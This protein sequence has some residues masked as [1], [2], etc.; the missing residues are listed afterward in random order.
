MNAQLVSG[1]WQVLVRVG[2]GR[3]RR[4][5]VWPADWRLQSRRVVAHGVAQRVLPQR[6]L[7]APRRD[8]LLVGGFTAPA[9]S[10]GGQID[11]LAERDQRITTHRVRLAALS[12][13]RPHWLDEACACCRDGTAYSDPAPVAIGDGAR[14]VTTPLDRRLRPA[15]GD[16]MVATTGRIWPRVDGPPAQRAGGRTGATLPSRLQVSRR[17]EAEAGQEV[18]QDGCQSSC[19]ASVEGVGQPAEE[20]SEQVARSGLAGDGEVHLIEV[21]DEPEHVQM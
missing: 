12:T 14:L 9:C 2:T 16:C 19:V 7:T 3:P 13:S 10:C 6:L 21:D 5:A 8:H 4:H 11:R 18:V 20:V 17:L 15:R 1:A